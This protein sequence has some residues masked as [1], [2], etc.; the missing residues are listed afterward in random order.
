MIGTVTISLIEYN[1]LRD[2]K[3][4]TLKKKLMKNH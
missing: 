1:E 4:K 3:L 2:F